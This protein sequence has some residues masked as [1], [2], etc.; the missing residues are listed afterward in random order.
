MLSIFSHERDVG[1]DLPRFSVSVR[2]D[3]GRVFVNLTGELD[4]AA[5]PQLR[6]ALTRAAELDARTTV[7]D[8]SGVTFIDA[9]AIGLLVGAYRS[10]VR[11]GV[12]LGVSRAEGQI[13]EVLG[14]LGLGDLIL[15]AAEA[16]DLEEGVDGHR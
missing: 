1:E 15:T 6:Q 8:L 16:G 13:A 12:I 3:G 10:A 9:H 4:M 11:R 7:I 2:P 14:V 5:G